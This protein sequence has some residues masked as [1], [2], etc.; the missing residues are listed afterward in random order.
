MAWHSKSVEFEQVPFW[1]VE[2]E[3]DLIW[4]ICLPPPKVS[5]F[6]WEVW[7]GKVLIM[8]QL[9]NRGFELTS[10]CPL[11]KEDEENLDHLL[12]HCPLV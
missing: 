6:T 4:N 10:R 9:K 7:W 12:L 3:A 2:L 5:V 8:N 1:Q 11:C